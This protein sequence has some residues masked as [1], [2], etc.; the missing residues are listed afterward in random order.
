MSFRKASRPATDS[1]VR[2][3]RA[4]IFAWQLSCREVYTICLLSV[5]SGRTCFGFLMP[6]GKMGV[7]A[8]AANGN[9]LGLF[10]DQPRAAA[11]ISAREVV[12]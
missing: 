2:E 9:L 11:A 7:E 12:P 3:P 10:P 6:R 5:Y 8:Y 4:V 1:T